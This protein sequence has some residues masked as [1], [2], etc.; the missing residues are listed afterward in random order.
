MTQMSCSY[1]DRDAALVSYLYDDGDEFGAAARV[2]FESHVTT[3]LP[4]RSELAE[5]RAVRS[6]LAEWA[7]PMPERAFSLSNRERGI[8]KLGPRAWWHQVPVWAQ[9]AA[10]MLVLGVSA[11]V[12]NLDIRYDKNQGLS[13]TTGWSKAA[14]A[15]VQSADLAPLRAEL[16]ALQETLRS[17]MRAQASTVRATAASSSSSGD[18]EVL[19]RVRAMLD[20]HDKNEQKELALHLTQMQID[21]NAQLDA[22]RRRNND[23]FRSVTQTVGN[24]I[25]KQQQQINYL[26]PAA[27][28]R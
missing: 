5:M 22:D 28:Q 13:I 27:S 14:P 24:Q 4:C 15:V 12:A 20:E 17:E 2:A 21:V 11:S 16:T 3:C 18:A 1:P 9:V 7:P 10:A 25:L 6:T 26:L 23:N 19:R 8:V